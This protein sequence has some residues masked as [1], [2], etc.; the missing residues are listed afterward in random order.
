MRK[1]LL[2]L[3]VAL[4]MISHGALAGVEV[5]IHKPT[6]IMRVHVDGVETYV[7][8]VSTAVRGYRTPAGTYK[9]Y[10]LDKHHY[11]SIYDNAPMPYSIFF[12]GGYAI[13]GTTELS[14]LGRPASHGCVRLDPAHAA[15]LFRLIQERGM[16]ATDIK[17]EE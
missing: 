1:M 13:H 15:M 5:T 7:W 12:H 16:S 2:G 6:Q 4:S 3:G 10:W 11:S 9:P 14:M 8:D 17:V